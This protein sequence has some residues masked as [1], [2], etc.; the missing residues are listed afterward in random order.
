MQV[1][2]L[3]VDAVVF[4]VGSRGPLG[5][6]H[7]AAVLDRIVVATLGMPRQIVS[8][9][10]NLGARSPHMI[11]VDREVRFQIV[12][13]QAEAVFQ[14]G[15]GDAAQIDLVVAAGGEIGPV[16][17]FRLRFGLRVAVL[18]LVFSVEDERDVVE[19]R[20]LGGDALLAN[21]ERLERMEQVLEG[22]ARQ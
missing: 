7:E 13:V 5:R 18:G 16:P 8:E 1:V 9:I 19:G 15:D 20:K 21:D 4:A 17:L 10:V 6:G 2:H 3:V 22:K 11:R 14:I 12:L